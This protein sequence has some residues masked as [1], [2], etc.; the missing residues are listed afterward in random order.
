MTAATSPDDYEWALRQAISA[1]QEDAF[2]RSVPAQ[3][4]IHV[5]WPNQVHASESFD[6]NA[7]MHEVAMAANLLWVKQRECRRGKV[8]FFAHDQQVQTDVG[9][10]GS[11]SRPAEG[12]WRR[13]RCAGSYLRSALG[14]D[15]VVIGTY[16]GHHVGFPAPAGSPPPDA[17]GMEDLLSALSIPRF[18]IDLRQLP[19]SGPPTNGSRPL[20]RRDKTLG[21]SS[22]SGLTVRF[23]ISI[24]S[25]HRQRLRNS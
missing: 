7:E 12:P 11:P 14:Q 5:K 15:V 21:A 10:L 18:I 20:M 6:H 4:N 8:L 1:V 3:W 25:R 17:H 13:I 23:S 22:H 19:G 16:D 2:L 24:S 9:V